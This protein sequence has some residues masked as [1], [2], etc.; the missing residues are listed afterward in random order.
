[1]AQ[2]LSPEIL[3]AILE[4]LSEN[5]AYIA[6]ARKVG[7]TNGTL[8]AWIAQAKKAKEENDRSFW[9][10]EWRE[11]AGWW[12]DFIAR[13]RAEQ[14]ATLDGLVR[15][16]TANGIE[17]VCIN[18]STGYPL[19]ALDPQWIGRDDEYMTMLGFDPARDRFLWNADG[20]QV[21][22]TKLEQVPAS[23][24]AK[25]MSAV[26]PGWQERT[27]TTVNVKPINIQFA[28]SPWVPKAERPQIVDAEFKEL[29]APK[30]VDQLKAE[31]VE[32]LRRQAAE[33]LANPD[34]VTKPRPDLGPV[35]YT[36]SGRPTAHEPLERA[37]SIPAD[38]PI[39]P[40]VAPVAPP[41]AAP[42][43]AAMPQAPAAIPNYIRRKPG[44]PQP[45]TRPDGSREP[46]TRVSG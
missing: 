43:P 12:I 7:C 34:R 45:Q 5:G 14:V 40:K 11:S 27:E 44:Q 17:V 3:I 29:P 6:A 16:Q 31:R 9:F 28:P 25:T 23:L 36:G 41:R 39:A 19:Q 42:A 24:R 33:H 37:G 15:S 10:V 13:A 20:S 35:Q 46:M 2:K 18:P 4:S 38:K 21:Y 30:T 32:I 22:Q 1:M 26:V 8:W